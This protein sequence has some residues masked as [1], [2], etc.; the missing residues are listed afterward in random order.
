MAQITR[1]SGRDIRRAEKV[2]IG[3]HVLRSVDYYQYTL[4][5]RSL[6]TVATNYHTVP[7]DEVV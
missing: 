3:S 7:W 4:I 1:D 6:I 5:C 2:L